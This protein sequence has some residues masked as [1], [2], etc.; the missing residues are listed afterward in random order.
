MNLSKFAWQFCDLKESRDFD[1]GFVGL[2]KGLHKFRY[3]ID[4]TYF[5]KFDYKDFSNADFT[6]DLDLKKASTMLELLFR[7]NGSVDLVCDLSL[8]SFK[9]TIDTEYELLIKFGKSEN[10][11][12]MD[13]VYLDYNAHK[14]NVAH[15]IY[16][17]IVLALPL[18]NVHPGIE[19]GSLSS[20]VFEKLK[21]FMSNSGNHSNGTDPRW[22][23][24]A[25]L[26]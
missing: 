4:Q 2:K 24:L 19:D 13:V 18:R 23:K 20:D 8:E 14:I 9:Q 16:E 22:A 15:Y 7:I 12:D 1:I 26:I 3:Q 11:Q 17:T 6:I 21:S 25:D 10:Q 5:E